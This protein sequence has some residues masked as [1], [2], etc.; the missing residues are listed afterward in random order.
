MILTSKEWQ[1]DANKRD[2]D[3]VDCS[4][5]QAGHKAIGNSALDKLI[6]NHVVYRHGIHLYKACQC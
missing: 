5:D 2:E 3:N 1:C 6:L 4:V